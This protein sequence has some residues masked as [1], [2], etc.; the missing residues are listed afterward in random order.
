MSEEGIGIDVAGGG[1]LVMALADIRRWHQGPQS[2][3]N[4][5]HL[6]SR[7]LRSSSSTA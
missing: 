2:S 1:E 6:S 4:R 7:H 3:S 5:D